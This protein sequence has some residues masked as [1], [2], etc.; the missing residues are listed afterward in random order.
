L[1]GSANGVTVI[2]AFAAGIGS[3]KISITVSRRDRLLVHLNGDELVF[4][5]DSDAPTQHDT[6]TLRFDDFSISK[7][8]TDNQFTLVWSVGVSVQVTPAF[9]NTV[10]TMVLNVAAAVSGEWKGNWTLGLIGGYDGNPHNDLRDSHGVVIGTVDTLTSQQI[11]EVNISNLLRYKIFNLCCFIL[12]LYGMTWAINPTR[13]LFHYESNDNALFYTS[14]NQNYRPSFREPIAGSLETNARQ[15]CGIPID[16]TNSSQWSPVQRTCYYDISV[17]G[18]IAFGRISRQAAEQQ[19]EQREAIRNPPKFNSELSLTQ[20]VHIGQEVH[21]YFQA[22]SEFS[23][24][25]AYKLLNGPNGASFNEGTGQ[26]QWKVPKDT[27]I[28]S[29]ISVQVSAQDATY[30]LTSTYE[31]VLNIHQKSNASAFS[32]STLLLIFTVA[33]SNILG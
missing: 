28:D 22:T 24:N 15:T 19:V 5:H 31:V 20:S 33:L 29:H 30:S 17:T 27:T 11:H 13:S 32:I 4:E 6:I 21:I 26:F 14:Q 1:G 8:L 3:L 2:K 23:S 12:K 9:V 16:S 7:N 18:D 25:V 10:S